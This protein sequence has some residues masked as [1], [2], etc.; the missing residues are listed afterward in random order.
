MV[1][2]YRPSDPVVSAPAAAVTARYIDWPA[3]ITGTVVATAISFVLNAFG[4]AIGLSVVSPFG[5]EGLGGTG[6]LIAVA[7]WMIWVTVSSFMV[8][9][10]VTGRMRHRAFDATEHESDVRDGVHGLAVWAS[11]VLLGLLI[12]ASGLDTTV[13]A[14]AQT[15]A[16]AAP[17]VAEQASD[18]ASD[19]DLDK[20]FRPAPDSVAGAPLR[21]TGDDMRAGREEVRTILGASDADQ[22]VSAD[23]R[24]YLASLVA[25][26]TGLDQQ[27]A[28][29]RVDE[30]AKSYA[31][32]RMAAKKAADMARRASVI[33]AFVLAASLLIAAAGA[34]WA[35]GMGGNHRDRQT[36]I[37]FFGRGR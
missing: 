28:A 4:A 27:Q 12:V 30:L 26:N 24:A 11:G 31:E 16:A 25:A 9:G 34:T 22:T 2:T 7:L 8:G 3:I 19:Y 29:A 1:D 13:R 20:L 36:V 21:S 15:V 10:Y 5:G 33:A 17:A 35:A 37:V 14:G 18:L 32:A 23:D 6:V